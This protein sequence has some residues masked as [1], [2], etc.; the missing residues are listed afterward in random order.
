MAW[1]TLVLS[2][3]QSK[4]ATHRSPKV[5]VWAEDFGFKE[6]IRSSRI[7]F[8]Q[9]RAKDEPVPNLDLGET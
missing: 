4:T 1:G 9:G 7:L 6:D 5:D 8:L 2:I 3:I